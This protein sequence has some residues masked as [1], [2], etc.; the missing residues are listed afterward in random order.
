I[1]L[2]LMTAGPML[3]S[4]AL[5]FTDFNLLSAPSW[6]G[7]E[8]YQRMFTQDP[9]FIKS[10]EVTTTYV[11]ISVP[12]AVAVALL[13]AVLLNQKVRW[14]GFFRSAYYLPS[15]L[16]GSVAIAILW[17]QIF[18]NEG[19]I[20]NLLATIGIDGPGW[21]TTPEYAVWSLI[22]LHV[23]QF[24]S[25]MVIFLAGLKQV[26]IELKEAASMDGAGT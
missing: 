10:I 11:L 6:V 5:S 16:G 2:G 7:L 19:L 8:N 14:L 21:I 26:P 13:V 9:R 18:G 1:G 25:P 20:N 3:A 23:W 4:L 15:L 12:L 22:F 17:R 24:G